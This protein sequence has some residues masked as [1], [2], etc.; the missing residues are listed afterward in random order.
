MFLLCL[1]SP[2][3]RKTFRGFDVVFLGA[4][5]TAAKKDDDGVP[6]LLQINP[7]SGFV[8]LGP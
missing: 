7:I 2:F 5:V 8:Y 4:L 1:G 6:T 3:P